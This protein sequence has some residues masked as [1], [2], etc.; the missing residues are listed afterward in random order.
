MSDNRFKSVVPAFPTREEINDFCTAGKTGDMQKLKDAL[1]K[2][3]RSIINEA[4]H[5]GDTAL[6]WA[7]WTGQIEAVKLLL[8]RGAPIDGP[9]MHGK[10]ALIWAVQGSKK[11]VITLLLERGAD[12]N[13]KD[14]NGETAFTMVDRNGPQEMAQF[15]R[16]WVEDQKRLAE[17]RRQEAEQQK[18]QEAARALAAERLRHLKD[19]APKLK[20]VP[21]GPGR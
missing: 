17:Q 9:G 14:N 19:K 18:Q 21:R 1:D 8:D 5:N 10:S 6:T 13:A 11:D 12:I 3:G 16:S 2:F 15:L 4:D 20:I 7:A